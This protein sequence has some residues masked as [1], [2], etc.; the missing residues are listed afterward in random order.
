MGQAS[1]FK[2][3]F[4]QTRGQDEENDSGGE[5]EIVGEAEGLLGG[6]EKIRQ[7][8]TE[9]RFLP[10]TTHDGRNEFHVRPRLGVDRL[11]KVKT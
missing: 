1:S 5:G 8:V 11:L 2:T 3:G 6:E 7:E 4:C 10:P 9:L